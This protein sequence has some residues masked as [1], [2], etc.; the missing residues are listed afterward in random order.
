MGRMGMKEATVKIERGDGENPKE[1]VRV[2]TTGRLIGKEIHCGGEPFFQLFIKKIIKKE[3]D[4][5]LS[6]QDNFRA[7]PFPDKGG[8]SCALVLA[9]QMKKRFFWKAC[10]HPEKMKKR[11][12]Q[13]IYQQSAIFLVFPPQR[14]SR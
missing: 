12:M 1:K 8:G 4:V 7:A 5:L 2:P 14:L 13:T 10:P 3:K 9:W 11:W 6:L